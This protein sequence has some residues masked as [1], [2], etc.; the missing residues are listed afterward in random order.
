M[1]NV[2]DQLMLNGSSNDAMFAKRSADAIHL[3]RVI[4]LPML[5]DAILLAIYQCDGNSND[6]MP[7]AICQCASCA[8]M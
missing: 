3:H 4:D 5:N 6:A 1:H 2:I 7:Q 8:T